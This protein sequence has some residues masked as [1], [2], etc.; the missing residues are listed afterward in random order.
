MMGR[1]V[2]TGYPGVD[3]FEKLNAA[4]MDV[5]GND[6]NLRDQVLGAMRSNYI[7]APDIAFLASSGFNSVRVPFHYKLF[8]QVTNSALN[9]PTNG[10][11]LETGFAYFDNLLSWC[12]SNAVLVIP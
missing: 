7:T 6:T 8:Y 12:S 9:Y 1:A 10:Y 4:L 3:T 11:D 5:L 2:F